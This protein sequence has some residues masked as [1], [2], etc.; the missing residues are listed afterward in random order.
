M[1]RCGDNM[2]DAYVQGDAIVALICLGVFVLLFLIGG[3][4]E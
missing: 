3:K 1:P 4:D 2:P